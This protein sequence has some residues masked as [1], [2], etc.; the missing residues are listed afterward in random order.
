MYWRDGRYY[1]DESGTVQIC[2]AKDK[3]SVTFAHCVAGLGDFQ[4]LSGSWRVT[5]VKRPLGVQPEEGGAQF[6]GA[7][8]FE[9]LSEA[10]VEYANGGDGF[11][12]GS[13]S[14]PEASAHDASVVVPF[15]C[16]GPST[17]GRFGIPA[18]SRDLISAVG[19]YRYPVSSG[20]WRF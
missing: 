13:E 19:G 10:Y 7:E 18:F 11:G 20:F 16:H 12:S 2:V 17:I 3:K 9:E 15:V 1:R 5:K 6:Y 8:Q 4:A 14:A